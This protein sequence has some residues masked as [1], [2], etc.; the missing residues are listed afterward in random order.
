MR[1]AGGSVCSF[2]L[3]RGRGLC[4]LGL[5]DSGYEFGPTG[6]AD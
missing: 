6:N 1:E 5:L 4:K 3:N 2:S